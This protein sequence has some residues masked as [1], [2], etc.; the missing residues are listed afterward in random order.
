MRAPEAIYT[1]SMRSVIRGLINLNVPVVAAAGNRFRDGLTEPDKLPSIMAEDF[2]VIVVGSA[3]REFQTAPTSQ[4]GNLVTTFAIGVDIKCADPLDQTG[5]ATDSGTSFAAPQVAGMVA[6]WISHPEFAGNLGPGLVAE[7]LRNM[8]GALSYP[9]VAE[10]GFPPIAWNGHD[11]AESCAVP[12]GAASRRAKSGMRLDLGQACSLVSTSVAAAPTSA[13]AVPPV[14]SVTS[15]APAPPVDPEPKCTLCGAE[16]SSG[17]PGT[18]GGQVGCKDAEVARSACAA[19]N[20]CKSWAF[21]FRDE[22][23]ISIPVCLL[24]EQSATQVVS[25]APPDPEG[26]CPFRYNDKGCI[27]S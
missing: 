5:L 2:P 12:N 14:A 24:F 18:L 19:D 21:G 1:T 8:T 23:E 4:R 9:R 6:Y 11:L 17:G 26:K 25:Q 10:P 20:T 16:T 27:S 22:G 15:V 7:T 3:G 13:P